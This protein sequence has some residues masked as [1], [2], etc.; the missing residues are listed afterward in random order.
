MLAMRQA[1]ERIERLEQA[2]RA[3]VPDWSLAEAVTALMAMRGMDLVSATTFLA[4]IGDLSR[5]QTPRELMAYLGWCRRSSRRAIRSFAARSPRPAMG[6]H[7]ACG[8]VRVELSA[9]AAGGKDKQEKVA[10]APRA[11]R[12][13]A[14]K[15]SAA[16][17]GATSAGQ[18]RQ[19]QDRRHHRGRARVRGF[20]SG[21]SRA[22]QTRPVLRAK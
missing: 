9:S 19:A 17:T 5:F 2:V 1:Q 4:E 3:A 16:S 21:R 12:E 8:G 18:E 13:I 20:S 22:R 6:G 15:R 14:W 10:A 11:V 7:D